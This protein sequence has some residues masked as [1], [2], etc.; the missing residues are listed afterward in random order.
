MGA[1]NMDIDITKLKSDIEDSINIDLTYSFTKEELEGTDLIELNNVKINGNISKDSINEYTIDVDVK[2]IMVLPCAITLDPVDYPF[3]VKI[4]G[5]LEEMLQEINE[6]SKK[7]ENSIDIFPIIWENILMEIP[8]KV[9]SEKAKN[10]KF[11][12]DG[13]RLITD[14]TRGNINPEFQKLSQ[15]FEEK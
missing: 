6:N 15:L 9:V 4:S 14:E 8:M 5:N 10:I 3:N 7:I 11:E 12:G 1:I 13:W 2:G